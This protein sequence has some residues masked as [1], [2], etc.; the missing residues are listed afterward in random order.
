MA[1]TTGALLG[2]AGIGAAGSLLSGFLGSSSQ[3]SAN[4]Q[5]LQIARETNEQ[6]KELFNKS[7][8]WQEDMWNKQNAYNDPSHLVELYQKA[9]VNPAQVF[10]SADT[11]A[12]SLPSVSSAQQIQQPVDHSKQQQIKQI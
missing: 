2:A 11:A 3:R 9:G 8:A 6:N 10:G 12:A 5:N 1:I 4:E 7:L